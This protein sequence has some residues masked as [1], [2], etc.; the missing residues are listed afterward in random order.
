MKEA[1]NNTD[2]A[3]Y[4][5]YKPGTLRQS[6]Y[7]KELAGVK[8]PVNFYR[9]RGAMYHV[10]ILDEWLDQFRMEEFVE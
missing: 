3:K 5:G 1:L 6:R 4:I 10:H 7:S 8:P 9:G 2:A